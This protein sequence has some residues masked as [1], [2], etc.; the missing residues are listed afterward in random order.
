M[1]GFGVAIY[2]Q[3]TNLVY[4]RGTVTRSKTLHVICTNV[5]SNA[6]GQLTT[7][8]GATTC[9]IHG[10]IGIDMA[11]KHIID[12]ID[13]GLNEKCILVRVRAI[14]WDRTS[15]I[16]SASGQ[17]ITVIPFCLRCYEDKK[18][19]E[20]MKLTDDNNNLEKALADYE[21]NYGCALCIERYWTENKIN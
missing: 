7:D 2:V 19:T 11:C 5:G 8:M 15:D 16:E 3:S 17:F 13:K 4:Q 10:D 18:M 9:D 21:I 12:N 14:P 20:K 1:Q 6:L